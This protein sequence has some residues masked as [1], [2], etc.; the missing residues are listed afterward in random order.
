MKLDKETT[1]NSGHGKHRKI[2]A[3]LQKNNSVNTTVNG[4]GQTKGRNK[5]Q[6]KRIKVIFNARKMFSK[7]KISF[8]KRK[9]L[10][11]VLVSLK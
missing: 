10:F 2:Q 1:V 5:L 9:C 3:C 6:V 4:E 8:P 11:E 7:N